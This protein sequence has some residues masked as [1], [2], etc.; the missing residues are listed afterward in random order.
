MM[1]SLL[2][3]GMLAGALAGLLVFVFAAVFGEPQ[4]N[5]AIA[6]EAQAAATGHEHVAEAASEPSGHSH[7]GEAELVSRGVQSTVGLG[8]AVIVYGAAIGGLFALAF[9]AVYG[10]IGSLGP[11]A[12]AG[13]LAALGFVAVFLV[14][15]IKYPANP[16][17]VGNPD[18]VALRTGLH[19]LMLVC[20]LVAL[21][22]A[23]RLRRSLV[24]SHGGWNGTVLAGGAYLVLVI[25][26]ILVLPG[27]NEVPD[28]FPALLLWDFRLVSFGMQ[29]LLWSALGLGFGLLAQRYLSSPR[30]LGATDLARG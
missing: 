28:G 6:L 20:S 7:G 16:P 14:P 18:T 21:A 19:L 30:A 22:I 5:L 13:L 12:T 15:A 11:Q 23:A 25:L 3:R 4:V 8:T 10:R 29:L 27:I 24:A 9:A 17:A 26:A 2:L 1:G